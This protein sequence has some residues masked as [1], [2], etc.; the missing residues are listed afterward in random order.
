MNFDIHNKTNEKT[1]ESIVFWLFLMYVWVENIP[2]IVILLA[3]HIIQY[4]FCEKILK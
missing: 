2:I 4:T 1:I 3:I